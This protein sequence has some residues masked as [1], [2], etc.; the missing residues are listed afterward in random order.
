M[1]VELVLSEALSSIVA[2]IELAD[3]NDI[4]PD[5]AS[6]LME[7]VAALLQS[8]SRED[9]ERIQSLIIQAAESERNSTRKDMILSIPEGFGLLD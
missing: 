1:S 4:D 8:A 7:P 3:D 6:S 2:S 9:R 5:V